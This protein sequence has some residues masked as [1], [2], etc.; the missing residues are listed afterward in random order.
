M[1][2][3]SL[4]YKKIWITITRELFVVVRKH[5]FFFD[6][7]MG[8]FFGCYVQILVVWVVFLD[9]VRVAAMRKTLGLG[10]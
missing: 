9:V 5:L 7:K 1:A 2:G 10:T 4:A 3:L 6:K 8:M